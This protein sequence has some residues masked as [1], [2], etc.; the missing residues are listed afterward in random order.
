MPTTT[1]GSPP[2]DRE[3]DA[4]RPPN[5]SPDDR[6]FIDRHGSR[7]S[8]TTLRAKWTHR[9]GEQPDRD[10]QTLATRN[11]AVIRDWAERRGAVPVAATVGD[12]GTPR[13]LRFAFGA[14]GDRPGSGRLAP[15]GWDAWLSVFER[16]QLVF[17][18]QER[19][20]DGS[21]SN[22]FRLDNPKRE[23]G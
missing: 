22:F 13:T 21:Q 14:R 11:H 2:G 20:R 4:A 23:D 10:G 3:T 18:Y 1:A 17:L 16:R 19:R 5:S 15:I 8:K 12:D 7:L 6:A 9:P